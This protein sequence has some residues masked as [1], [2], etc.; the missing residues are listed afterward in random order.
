MLG[1][2]KTISVTLDEAT[3]AALRRLTTEPE[4]RSRSAVVRAA[5]LAL[6]ERTIRTAREERERRI[7]RTHRTKLS[8]QAKALMGEQA[9]S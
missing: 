6:S 4:R 9:D 3:L 5:V 8:R 7:L 2:M 1:N